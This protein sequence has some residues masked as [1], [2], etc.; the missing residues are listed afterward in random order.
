MATACPT[1]V[2]PGHSLVRPYGSCA[3]ELYC[4]G[5]P[6]PAGPV[7]ILHWVVQPEDLRDLVGLGLPDGTHGVLPFAVLFLPAGCPGVTAR[8]SHLPFSRRPAPAV[9]SGG[10]PPPCPFRSSLKVVAATGACRGSWDFSL[11]AVRTPSAS[12]HG[13]GPRLPWAFA[14]LR[15]SSA[16]SRNR[17]RFPSA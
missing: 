13:G 11:R 6:L 9:Y 2:S 8:R 10:Q 5:V 7:S 14:S 16:S 12:I 17:F 3:A 4:C 15:A 1:R